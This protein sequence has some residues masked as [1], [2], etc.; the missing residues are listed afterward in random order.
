VHPAP[1][2]GAGRALSRFPSLR[3]KACRVA[4]AAPVQQA[5]AERSRRPGVRLPLAS[6]PPGGGDDGVLVIAEDRLDL[7]ICLANRLAFLPIP[8]AIASLA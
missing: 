4:G 8:G 5:V 6:V 3:L 7:F 1:A 2:A